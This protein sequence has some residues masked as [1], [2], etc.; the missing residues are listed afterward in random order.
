MYVHILQQQG[1]HVQQ[2]IMHVQMMF[3]LL[4]EHVD[5]TQ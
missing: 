1:L 3:V 2:I 4:A 5:I